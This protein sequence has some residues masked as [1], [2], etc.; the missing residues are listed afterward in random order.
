MIDASTM[1]GTQEK[2][3][4]TVEEWKPIERFPGYEVST[5][6]RVRSWRFA[7]LLELQQRNLPALGRR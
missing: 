2:V 5:L 3:D 1:E 4:S 6:G 7:G